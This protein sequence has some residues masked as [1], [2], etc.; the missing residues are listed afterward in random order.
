MKL[1]PAALSIAGIAAVLYAGHEVNTAACLL[2]NRFDRLPATGGAVAT[3]TVKGGA[4]QLDKEVVGAPA[5]M[6]KTV[7]QNAKNT[8]SKTY[9]DGTT[10]LNRASGGLIRF[11]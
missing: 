5:E 6:A 7:V 9:K 4:R 10:A 2:A 8:A 11:H 1:L 3:E